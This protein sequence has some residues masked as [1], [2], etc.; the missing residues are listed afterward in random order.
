[1]TQLLMYNF[2]PQIIQL[3][4]HDIP[5]GMT[6][7]FLQGLNAFLQK[8]IIFV[9]TI[10]IVMFLIYVLMISRNFLLNMINITFN[11]GGKTM[12]NGKKM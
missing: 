11:G 6:F 1:M 2:Y 3:S 10:Q 9:E 5:K 12:C 7:F 4:L 8:K